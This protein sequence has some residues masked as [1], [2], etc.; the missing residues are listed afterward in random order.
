MMRITATTDPPMMAAVLSK[1]VGVLSVGGSEVG[2][3]GVTSLSVIGGWHSP[4]PR[5]EVAT[6][7]SESTVTSTPVTMILAPPLTHSSI[8]EMSEPLSVSEVPSSLARYVT[9]VGDSE[10][11]ANNGVSMNALVTPHS[12]QE[13]VS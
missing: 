13:T 3:G 12:V 11:Q 9:D 4:S 10:K 8:R 7:H 5:D 2:S 1:V 6:G